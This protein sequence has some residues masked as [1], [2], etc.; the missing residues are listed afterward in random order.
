MEEQWIKSEEKEE[1]GKIEFAEAKKELERL[2][3]EEKN[4]GMKKLKTEVWKT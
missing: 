3:H 4:R 1:I 2:S